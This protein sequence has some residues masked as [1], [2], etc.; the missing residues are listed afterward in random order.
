MAE[1][2]SS[3]AGLAVGVGLGDRLRRAG[4]QFLDIFRSRRILACAASFRYSSFP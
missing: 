1:P 2:V 3:L 4:D